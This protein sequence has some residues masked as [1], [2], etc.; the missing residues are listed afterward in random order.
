MVNSPP[1]RRH[2][3]FRARRTDHSAANSRP[4]SRHTVVYTR[5]D[6]SMVN[7]ALKGRH[8]EFP[9]DEPTPSIAN[10]PATDEAPVLATRTPP[11]RQLTPVSDDAP[12]AQNEPGHSM[13]NSLRDR[14]NV[15]SRNAN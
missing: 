3:E 5:T 7:S 6:H 8:T 11:N 4:D 12:S 10:S 2:A 1:N 13:A 15:S 14:R 9:Q